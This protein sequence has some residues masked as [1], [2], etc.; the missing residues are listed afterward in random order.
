MDKK[1]GLIFYL[2]HEDMFFSYETK[3]LNLGQ[4]KAICNYD[5]YVKKN[6]YNLKF[7]FQTINNVLVNRPSSLK[8]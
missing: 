5:V 1:C 3:C 8:M 4:F 6:Y 7:V 2:I